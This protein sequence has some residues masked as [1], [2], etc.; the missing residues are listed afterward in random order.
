MCRNSLEFMSALLEVCERVL[1]HPACA[2]EACEPE[3]K[4]P[5][6]HWDPERPL[7]PPLPELHCQREPSR[8]TDVHQEDQSAPASHAVS[9]R[10]PALDPLLQRPVE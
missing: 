5:D 6:L 8:P 3:P 4:L 9:Q 2:L 7:S 1:E 10:G